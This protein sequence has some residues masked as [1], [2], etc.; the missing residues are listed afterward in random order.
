[1]GNLSGATVPIII[2]WLAKDG[3]FQPALIFITVV[4]LIG[5]CSYF[6]LV[7]KIE[8]IEDPRP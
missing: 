8:R 7:G 3:D 6:F 2:G 4:S 1:M 5:F